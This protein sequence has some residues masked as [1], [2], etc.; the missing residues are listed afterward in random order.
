MGSLTNTLTEAQQT[1][2]RLQSAIKDV[3][4]LVEPDAPLR[5]DLAVMLEQLGSALN[6]VSDLAEFLQRNP[7]SLLTGRKAPNPKQ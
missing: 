2:V 3:A 6:S 1:L 7:N 5:A 4:G